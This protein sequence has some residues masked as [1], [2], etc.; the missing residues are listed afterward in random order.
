MSD[1]DRQTD[2]ANAADKPQASTNFDAP[3][4]STGFEPAAPL[5]GAVLDTDSADS[6]GTG[7]AAEAGTDTSGTDVGG[8]EKPAPVD[9]KQT[10]IDKAGE[11]K[12]QAT[13]RVRTLAE[14][15]KTR[16]TGAL[17]ELSKVLTDAAD[18]VDGKLGGQYG[19]YA[20]DAADRVQGLS[21]SIDE[22]SL[23]EL[24][25][26]GRDM[27]RKSPA[28]AIGVAATAGFVVAR[29][30]TAGLDQRDAA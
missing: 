9:F 14:D 19:Q 15:G 17:G 23:E 6:I 7:A 5:K 26:M 12:G 13:E 20:R 27:V 11:L 22:K 10:L 21:A 30:L 29:L 8:D 3:A 1:F 16:A 25:D 18:Q 28:L 4:G 24:L 2:S